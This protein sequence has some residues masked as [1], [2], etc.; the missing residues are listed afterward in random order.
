MNGY[1]I[2]TEKV[3]AHLKSGKSI[4]SIEAATKMGICHLQKPIQLLRQQGLK[5]KDEW[6]R[7]THSRY[8]RYWL[9]DAI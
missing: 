8:K 9:E 3:L 5:I 7:D 1:K 6:Q 2:Q 4:T